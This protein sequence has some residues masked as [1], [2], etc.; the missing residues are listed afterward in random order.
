MLK[1]MFLL[2]CV[3]FYIPFCF[4]YLSAEYL[5][6]ANSN[7]LAWFLYWLNAGGGDKIS[8]HTI[9]VTLLQLIYYLS[10]IYSI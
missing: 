4:V 9:N 7:K 6:S 2:N 1:K 5:K 3:L 10:Y 8:E